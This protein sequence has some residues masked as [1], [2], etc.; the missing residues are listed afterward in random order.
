MQV[1]VEAGGHRQAQGRQPSLSALVWWQQG[2]ACGPMQLLSLYF[3]GVLAAC[4]RSSAFLLHASGPMH[5]V[6]NWRGIAVVQLCS[7]HSISECSAAWASLVAGK[8]THGASEGEGRPCFPPVQ[9]AANALREGIS[10]P[11]QSTAA[12]THHQLTV[13]PHVPDD[14]HVGGVEELNRVAPLLAPG[15][16]VAHGQVHAEALEVD[17]LHECSARVCV[18]SSIQTWSALLAFV[19]AEAHVQLHAVAPGNAPP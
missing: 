12:R 11:T 2:H 9:F 17:H 10:N 4:L 1:Q 3:A 15:A 19:H 18:C 5:S 16:L 8:D 13:Q 14:G 7:K 6:R